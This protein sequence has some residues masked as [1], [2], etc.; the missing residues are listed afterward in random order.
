M[1]IETLDIISLIIH[2]HFQ[3]LG[4]SFV[5]FDQGRVLKELIFQLLLFQG[6]KPFFLE[7]F[8]IHFFIFHVELEYLGFVLVLVGLDLLMDGLEAGFELV[9]SFVELADEDVLRVDDGW[10]GEDGEDVVLVFGP[11]TSLASRAIQAWQVRVLVQASE[12]QEQVNILYIFQQFLILLSLII[13]GSME[14]S[15]LRLELRNLILYQ[16]DM[17]DILPLISSTD[18]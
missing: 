11:I 13:Y 6:L 12:R 15:H 16:H 9:D 17:P 3:I 5:N 1:L 14:L 2:S 18:D 8:L 10:A 7:I 4:L